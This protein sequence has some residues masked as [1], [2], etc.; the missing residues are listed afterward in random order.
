MLS[1]LI[2]EVPADPVA[3]LVIPLLVS[4]CRARLDTMAARSGAAFTGVVHALQ[5]SVEV[6]VPA[7]AQQDAAG[8]ELM[9]SEGG[10]VESEGPSVSDSCQSKLQQAST[11]DSQLPSCFAQQAVSSKMQATRFLF[12]TLALAVIEQQQHDSVSSVVC[13]TVRQQLVLAL[14]HGMPPAMGAAI[15]EML[16][17]VCSAASSDL[18]RACRRM[19]IHAAVLS[20]QPCAGF[21]YALDQSQGGLTPVPYKPAAFWGDQ[22]LLFAAPVDVT[23]LAAERKMA[24]HK[25]RSIDGCGT[26]VVGVS[27]RPE[28]EAIGH[29]PDAWSVAI[30]LQQLPPGCKLPAVG[31]LVRQELVAAFL[32]APVAD[33]KTISEGLLLD[34]KGHQK[35][36]CYEVSELDTFARSVT[37]S[38]APGVRVL[39][40]HAHRA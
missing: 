21:C 23:A 13:R 26:A 29:V 27:Q 31:C 37:L 1:M 18:S 8:P 33:W 3:M 17:S 20:K 14:S 11:A 6:P 35:A 28:G 7:S 15:G 30:M 4:E 36:A 10:P 5:S 19:L 39:L 12:A 24:R 16:L 22:G 34:D 2:K 38:L 40:L 32:G 9:D 25:N